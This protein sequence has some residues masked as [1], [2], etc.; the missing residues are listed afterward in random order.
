LVEAAA[1]KRRRGRPT[2]KHYV[3]SFVLFAALAA[4]MA[5][6]GLENVFRLA[7]FFGS[8]AGA[9]VAAVLFFVRIRQQRLAR[10]KGEARV[11]TGGPI[12]PEKS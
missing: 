11:S 7:L 8:C 12:D 1:M 6:I 9:V 2:A 3:I 5:F 4:N 10:T